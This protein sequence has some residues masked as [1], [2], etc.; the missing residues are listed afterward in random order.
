MQPRSDCGLFIKP[1]LGCT[2]RE[3]VAFM[4]SIPD[5]E[6]N[7]LLYM[8][9]DNEEAAEDEKEAAEDKREAVGDEKEAAERAQHGASASPAESSARDAPGSTKW[10][11]DSSNKSRKYKRNHIRL[12]LVPLL[13][14]LSGGTDALTKRLET[15]AH[16]S[17]E[18]HDW[19]SAE[20][21]QFLDSEVQ[22]A[23]EPDTCEF[24]VC[25]ENSKF[26][27]LPGPIQ[28]KIIHLLVQ[29]HTD[30]RPLSLPCEQVQKVV[31]IAT[32]ALK[33]GQ[34][35]SLKLKKEW[36]AQR[37]GNVLRIHRL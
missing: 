10:F 17:R 9:Q 26:Y 35:K 13:A 29:R 5:S 11:E 30:G 19:L 12:D 18:L 34:Y 32:I 3:L 28:A 25:P 8:S 20:A 2:K 15:L 21:Q 27:H 7:Q 23:S 37:V 22:Y 24:S 14:E 16:Q 1:L 4:E 36:Q 33:N 6:H 31:S